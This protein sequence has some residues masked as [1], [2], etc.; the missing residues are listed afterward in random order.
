MTYVYGYFLIWDSNHINFDQSN[1]LS[2]LTVR[3]FPGDPVVRIPTAESM[4]SI[5]GWGTKI[6]H[7]S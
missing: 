3:E 4:G 7:G 6:P 2:K 5:P 1:Q